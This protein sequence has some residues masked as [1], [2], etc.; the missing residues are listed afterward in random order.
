MANIVLINPRFEISYGGLDHAMPFL[1]PGAGGAAGAGLRGIIRLRR[2]GERRRAGPRA[3]R[4]LLSER[5]PQV[6]E[7]ETGPS[8]E[9]S[10]AAG[11]SES[12]IRYRAFAAASGQV[13]ARAATAAL[14]LLLAV[15][16]S[17]L[18]EDAR[19]GGLGAVSKASSILRGTEG[20]NPSS[21]IRV[22]CEP[23]FIPWRTKKDSTPRARGHHHCAKLA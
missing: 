16:Q 21:P 18:I 1:A 15:V 22:Y 23:D 8:G 19:A 17:C 2:R 9:G 20:S 13:I 3:T 7:A 4:R 14:E 12:W 5:R 11:D 6:H 10:Y